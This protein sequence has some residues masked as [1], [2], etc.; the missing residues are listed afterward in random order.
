MKTPSSKKKKKGSALS[1]SMDL[2]R[3]GF[4]VKKRS[5][6]EIASPSP[7]K[8]ASKNSSNNNNNNN[9]GNNNDDAKDGSMESP[10]KRHKAASPAAAAGKSM[11]GKGKEN[12]RSTATS[13]TTTIPVVD[14][15]QKSP[16]A[17]ATTTTTTTAAASRTA[18]F[19]LTQS[20]SGS[21]DCQPPKKK[22]DRGG[23][24]VGAS[25]AGSGAAAANESKNLS[26]LG[27]LA[28][29]IANQIV[30]ASSFTAN[31]NN[32]SNNLQQQQAVKQR[33][34]KRDKDK[35]ANLA[36][37][38]NNVVVEV[39]KQSKPSSSSSSNGEVS[40]KTAAVTKKSSPTKKNGNHNHNF[41]SLAL[42][43]VMDPHEITCSTAVANA[44]RQQSKQQQQQTLTP[45]RL[46]D[47]AI[48]GRSSSSATAN[49]NFVDL[50]IRNK[51]LG[52]S[53]N[54]ITILKVR[55]AGEMQQ[56]TS[57]SQTSV[58]SSSNASVNSHHCDQSTVLLQVSENASNG[59][60]IH[61]TKRGARNVTYLKRGDKLTLRV[62][63]AIQFYST[64]NF[65]YCVVGLESQGEK[66]MKG[67]G[68]K[69]SQHTGQVE[70]QT[71]V[72]DLENNQATAK[73]SISNEGNDAKRS[74][75]SKEKKKLNVAKLKV[76][77]EED[78]VDVAKA[79]FKTP[80]NNST[81]NGAKLSAA[82][83]T[84]SSEEEIEDTPR[85]PAVASPT[86][87]IK[88]AT[89]K[90]AK[91]LDE[92][93]RKSPMGPK[94]PKR[95]TSTGDNVDGVNAYANSDVRAEITTEGED[96][97]MIK[98]GDSVKARY[99]EEDMFGEFQFE[100]YF[101][102]VKG[103]RKNKKASSSSPT[104]KID[105][106]F[107]NEEK[108]TL[109]FPEQ[110]EVEKLASEHS[111][112]SA[113]YY[114][115]EFLIGDCVDCY[116]QDGCSPGH[117]GRWYRG[118]IS[119]ISEDGSSC[120][121]FYLDKDYEFNIPTKEKKIRL[122]KRADVSGEWM[123]NK[124]A[125]ILISGSGS[126]YQYR[127]GLVTSSQGEQFT[128]EFSDDGTTESFA[129][130]EVATGVFAYLLK[131][132]AEKNKHLWP[133]SSSSMASTAR[134]RRQIKEKITAM[135]KSVNPKPAGRK[136]SAPN[137]RVDKVKV[138]KSTDVDME[139]VV[140]EA[141]EVPIKKEIV[142]S[143]LHIKIDLDNAIDTPL[144][145]GQRNVKRRKLETGQWQKS[146]VVEAEDQ[147]N[148]SQDSNDGQAAG[149]DMIKAK[150]FPPGIA[151]AI[152]CGLNSPE[153]QTSANLLQNMLVVQNIVPPLHLVEKLMDL[154]KYGPKS[155]GSSVYFKDPLRTELASS[156]AYALVEASSRLVR[157]DDSALFGPSS[158]DDVEVLLSQSIDQT[159]NA[160][161]GRRLVQGL[162]MAACG[163]KL[164]SLML[165]T[166][167]LDS[168]LS[169]TR[170]SFDTLSVTLMPTVNVL[171]TEGLRNALK[172]V[173]RHTTKCMVR[174]S[175]WIL[176]HNL[177]ELSSIERAS[178]EC[179]A[180]EA[181]TCFDSLGSAL[182]YTAWL[183]CAEE[184]I[185]INHP[186]CAFVVKDEFLSELT[187]CIDNLPEMTSRKKTTFVK[188][189]KLHFL[190][191]FVEEFAFPLQDSVGKMIGLEGLL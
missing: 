97:E 169:S 2:L 183:F 10:L 3:F 151:T 22:A 144:K 82:K 8:S 157:R 152:W 130:K 174:H 187:R 107:A 99:Q 66:I 46:F 143:V 121:V 108:D 57:L 14:D 166:E 180:A 135:K 171:K 110:D 64:E 177:N 47:G 38:T 125:T 106:V 102:K 109:S 40:Q 128:V 98:K 41:Q 116:Y 176:D 131:D 50:G 101:G 55:T 115:E 63:D 162:H 23:S 154:L 7:N 191:S 91:R 132:I 95:I 6:S 100:W 173:V 30:A 188:K 51:C 81:S 89:K 39:E 167:L 190:L 156:Y 43:R 163:A 44:R 149:N 139:D 88:S 161:S 133:V 184:G 150:D 155:E 36:A 34:G 172:A 61:R 185:E 28:S 137:K 71:E 146:V 69:K 21:E 35:A 140:E 56:H 1:P 124:K 94:S 111:M 80:R 31:N 148:E 141:E 84:T 92:K 16:V 5:A 72:I 48:L 13:T 9:A 113:E 68:L 118:R 96:N 79:P 15:K 75:S 42:V 77:G 12:G 24:K 147:Y 181:K 122:I 170:F 45:R 52:I 62:G 168:D 17:T 85:F 53:R 159:E 59:V 114:P 165:K 32:N 25:N 29:S 27:G 153:P 4:S 20:S 136:T 54:H 126:T 74:V 60:Q 145:K 182:C 158:W 178:A 120:D 129:Y 78:V 87:E 73:K 33:R 160:I 104:Y 164:L 175:K 179:C 138:E 90:T 127:T 37:K 58:A 119:S 65:Y 189:L 93:L 70:K 117:E 86:S 49:A 105:V 142:R 134:L 18:L 19:D 103:V 26:S 11:V 67:G 83:F 112:D 186:N 123:L 76:T